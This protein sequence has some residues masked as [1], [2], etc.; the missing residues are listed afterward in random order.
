MPRDT[1]GEK[2]ALD[3]ILDVAKP[4]EA[5]I[6]QGSAGRSP[7][8]FKDPYKP[9]QFVHT[10][11][12]HGLQD[13]WNR[14]IRFTNYYKDYLSFA[15]HTGDF[16]GTAADWNDVCARAIPCDRPILQSTGNHDRAD[17]QKI[18]GDGAKALVHSH[19]F[20]H[21]ED[22]D[23]TYMDCD[24]PMAYYKDFPESN[25]RLIVLDLY[26]DVDEQIKWL[27]TLLNRSKEEGVSVMTATHQPTANIVEFPDTTFTT[28]IDWSQVYKDYQGDYPIVH[29]DFEE[30]I[31]DFIDAGGDYICH[32]SG[33]HH[34]PYFG[35]TE[36]GVLNLSVGV[37][38]PW[39]NWND[40][41]RVF[42]SEAYDSFNVVSVD[43]N[44]H[45]LRII[46]IGNDLD[47]YLRR[48]SLLTYDYKNKKVIYN[49]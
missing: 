19:I 26:F 38:N 46:R 17:A 32:L 4:M 16:S 24:Y 30:P 33:H 11:D 25:I 23:V 13:P 35:Y 2:F 40:S 28:A 7:F 43:V 21:T 42:D 6:I 47:Y 3:D 5:A 41:K 34:R 14:M 49:G 18:A 15:I 36:R 29:T 39:G 20:N 8:L 37:G 9:L 48:Q 45:L 12:M 10:A 44:T 1:I 31:A 22:W 27:T